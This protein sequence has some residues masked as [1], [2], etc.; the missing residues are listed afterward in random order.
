MLKLTLCLCFGVFLAAAML[1]L[2]QENLNLNYQTSR[3]HSQ[4]EARQAEL[5]SQQLRIAEVTAPNAIANRVRED[6]IPLT[7]EAK[8]QS[9]N[10]VIPS[11][12]TASAAE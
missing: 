3:L 8:T 4:I 11:E 6:N 7:P 2:R 1:Q 9:K 5:W 10:W 12:P